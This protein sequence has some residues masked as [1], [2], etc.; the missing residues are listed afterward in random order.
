MKIHSFLLAAAPIVSVG[1]YQTDVA[2]V[3]REVTP[4]DGV[5]NIRIDE[6]A[7]FAGSLWYSAL[8]PLR[9]RE[10]DGERSVTISFYAPANLR[11]I[12]ETAKLEGGHCVTINSNGRELPFGMGGIDWNVFTVNGRIIGEDDTSILLA[13]GSYIKLETRGLLISVSGLSVEDCEATYRGETR[14]RFL[15]FT[16]T[17]D[18]FKVEYLTDGASWSPAYRLELDGDKA[19]I[20]MSGE[21]ENNLANWE[22]VEVSLISGKC[23]IYSSPKPENARFAPLSGNRYLSL[24]KAKNARNDADYYEAPAAIGGSGYDVN[25]ENGSGEDVHY[26][27]IGKLS[28][29]RGE[30][31]TIPLGCEKV[32]IKR[33]VEWADSGVC[34]DAVKFKNPFKFPMTF[35]KM[36][37][38]EAGRILGMPKVEW[39]NPGAETFVKI[40]EASSIKSSYEEVRES[41][42]SFSSK[43]GSFGGETTKIN[44]RLYGKAKISGV[45]K[46]TNFRSEKALLNV[47]RI[48]R[49]EIIE[50]SFEPTK[51]K[52]LPSQDFGINPEHELTWEFELSPNETREFTVTYAHW[53][54]L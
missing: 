51:T 38:T 45:F 34:W 54:L 11:N 12:I 47:K 28:L 37:V 21:I 16:G 49:G 15:E 18:P 41:K 19:S 14:Q 31:M 13:S 4:K 1:L 23:N 35:A 3:T 44:G 33:I 9:I 6:H 32:D 5:A 7:P 26:R 20:V 17:K 24:S 36:E 30:T 52:D 22:D 53:V 40:A 46:L 48:F 43:V 10:Y 39:T 27:P 8:E 2:V 25:M 29:K 42:S 50:S